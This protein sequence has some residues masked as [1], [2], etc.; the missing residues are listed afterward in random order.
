MAQVARLGIDQQ[1]TAGG[2]HTP[3]LMVGQAG[4]GL[5]HLGLTQADDTDIVPQH[6]GME[7]H[8]VK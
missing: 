3:G 7:G 5:L 4:M 8:G 6:V 2:G 1:A